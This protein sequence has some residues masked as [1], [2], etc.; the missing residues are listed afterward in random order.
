[1]LDQQRNGY[2]IRSTP[3]TK[4]GGGWNIMCD[5]QLAFVGGVQTVSKCS[6]TRAGRIGAMKKA[7]ATLSIELSIKDV[8]LLVAAARRAVVFE[9][10]SEA[11]AAGL[12]KEDDIS[13]AIEWVLVPF[14]DIIPGVDIVG[15]RSEVGSLDG[16]LPSAKASAAFK[17][18]N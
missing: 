4:N 18:V 3:R 6:L 15:I 17:V 1:M 5:G 12:I 11:E 13:S 14:P 16:R 8:T 2:P 10:R 9:G 7:R